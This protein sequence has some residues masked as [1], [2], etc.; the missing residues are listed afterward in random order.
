MESRISRRTFLKS[1]AAGA[2]GVAALG[3]M[4]ASFAMEQ[5]VADVGTADWLGEAPVI[6]DSDIAETLETEVLIVGAGHA[7]M[8]AGV[9]ISEKGYKTLIIEKNA[10]F[11]TVRGDLGGMGSQL[12]QEAGSDKLMDERNVF[13]QLMMYSAGR[14]DPKL[15]R[16]WMRDSGKVVD[17]LD[18]LLQ[19]K[20]IGYV[21]HD[22]GYEQ[23]NGFESDLAVGAYTKFPS[24][25]HISVTNTELGRGAEM[26]NTIVE[27]NGGQVLFETGM[28]DLEY[29]DRKVS[30]I[31][32]FDSVNE[33]YIRIKASKGVVLATGG[34]QEDPVMFHALQPHTEPYTTPIPSGSR[35]GDG[36]RACLWMGAEMD[37]VH[38]S[39]LFD[40]RLLLPGTLPYENTAIINNNLGSQP[41]LKLNLDGER[42]TNESVP[43]DYTLHTSMNYPG[44]CFCEIIDDNFDKDI[45]QF[46]T[47][48]CSRFFGYPNRLEGDYSAMKEELA[49]SVRERVLRSFETQMEGG[50]VVQADTIEELAEKMMLPV[51]KVLASVAR[52]NELYEKQYDEDFFKESYRLSPINT[53]PYYGLRFC[54]RMLSTID[55]I[56]IDEYM[57]PLDADNKP[58]D[59]LFVIGD[60]SGG[61]FA[62]TYP[63]LFTGLAAGRSMTWAWRVANI[64]S[65]EIEMA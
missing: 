54:G 64:L 3:M 19:E 45:V 5:G 49:A 27:N 21:Y 46:E 10:M 12:Q 31:I 33:K 9:F 22:G 63:N 61:F 15:I 50:Y 57:R 65:G 48:G 6:S 29:T 16:T 14:A 17:Y 23:L 8:F 60:C 32:A 7:G 28:V 34:Y 42:F 55:G 13:H 11:G 20:E 2:A 37:A 35:S 53:P 59:G 58:F 43:Y 38:T 41:F 25:H 24:G 1:A 62:H 40:R 18:Q 26:L 56:R 30:G 4:G 39:M 52:Y 36:I 51:E 44:H 47:V